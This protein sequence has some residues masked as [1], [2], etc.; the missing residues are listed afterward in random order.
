MKKTV[1]AACLAQLFATQAFSAPSAFTLGEVTV[2]A[3]TQG[4]EKM[5]SQLIESD[6]IR[7]NDRATVG[8]ALNLLPGVHLSKQG[9]RNEQ[10]IWVRG[11]NLRQVPVYEDGIPIYVPYDGYVDFG[12]FTTYDLANIEVS[13][14][15]SSALYGANTLGGAI[16][17]VSRRPTGVFE[18]EV[19]GGLDFTSRGEQGAQR[20]YTNLGTNQGQWYMQAGLSYVNQ[21]FYR[22]SDN[23]SPTPA[24]N[25]GKRENSTFHDGKVSLKF[26]LTPNASDEYAISY[27]NQR[28]VKDAPPYAGNVP[29]HETP[30]YW[31]WPHWDKE[32][33]RL[34]TSTRLGEHTLKFRLYHDI[35]KNSLWSYDDAS[36]STLSKKSSFKSWYDDV[37]TG[38][39]VQDDIRLSSD[40]LLRA[41][42]NFKE[43]THRE[44]NAGEPERQFKDRNTS[45]ALEDTHSF[46]RQLSLVTGISVE[47]RKT[48][49]AQDYNSATMKISDFVRGDGSATNG[50]VGVFYKLNGSDSVRATVA[51]KSRFPTIKDRYS[52]KMGKALPNAG[53]K[54]EEATH[55]EL[56]WEGRLSGHWMANVAVFHSDIS[57]LIQSTT[58]DV[59]CGSAYCFQNQNIGK[60]TSDGLELGARGSIGRWD[61][62]AN[63]TYLD[64]QNKVN[65]DKLTDTPRHKLFATAVWSFAPSWSATGVVEAYSHRYSSSDGKQAV[66]AFVLANLKLGY[67]LFGGT[68]I[69]AGVRNIFDKTYRYTEGYPEAGRNYF[70]QFN[71]PL[72]N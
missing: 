4:R 67:R 16:N 44:H 20:V 3:S 32:S 48:L 57:N 38:F 68:L 51:Q 58:L 45:F 65:S 1:V 33:I 42:Y 50:Q 15:F 22:L 64:R 27:I 46:T 11:F 43:D 59:K 34:L 69:E 13:K 61:L 53:L 24:E 72:G 37:T 6:E 17:L 18:G 14:G 35:L 19:G 8:E 71:T 66:G 49:E 47:R 70:V 36:Y 55:Y 2:S 40:N 25:G 29:T 28:G 30:S 12:R 62:L 39:S 41:S 60:A 21:D 10:M 63:Y 9:K 7:Q 31:R 5:G 54:M 23:F 56:G 52:Y 26:A